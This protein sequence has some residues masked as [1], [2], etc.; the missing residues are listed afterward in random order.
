MTTWLFCFV[1]LFFFFCP[2]FSWPYN[3]YFGRA[4]KEYKLSNAACVVMLVMLASL[5][6]MCVVNPLSTRMNVAFVH[7][8]HVA[9][10]DF[11]V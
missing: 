8:F 9:A 11:V 1:R 10:T 4:R 7:T 2:F 3:I 5:N 6:K